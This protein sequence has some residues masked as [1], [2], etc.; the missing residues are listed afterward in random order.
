MTT[1][2]QKHLDGDLDPA[3]LT[4]VE[5]V[6]LGSVY[7]AKDA[8]DADWLAPRD[9]KKVQQA[10]TGYDQEVAARDAA[11][12]DPDSDT[13]PE[14]QPWDALV[15]P[16]VVPLLEHVQ[17]VAD[18]TQSYAYHFHEFKDGSRIEVR[19]AA[20]PL[21]DTTERATPDL[22]GA[23]AKTDDGLFRL[24]ANV[25]I[26]EAGL[27]L[28]DRRKAIE[29]RASAQ[30][31]THADIEGP[32][33]EVDKLIANVRAIELSDGSHTWLPA[34]ERTVRFHENLDPGTPA[35]LPDLPPEP[36]AE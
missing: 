35:I 30:G 26:A 9:R 4:T 11:L 25:A 27:E 28:L 7:E 29:D 19:A 10:V 34:D 32:L 36:P 31:L 6:T 17:R 15:V 16:R 3:E 1:L 23:L 8:L 22:E 14:V 33:A 21:L 12:E 2:A 18:E 5:N 24:H 13:A 20:R